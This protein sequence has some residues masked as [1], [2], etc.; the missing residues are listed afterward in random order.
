MNELKIKGQGASDSSSKKGFVWS[1]VVVVFAGVLGL[2]F[3]LMMDRSAP[4]DV[5]PDGAT[6]IKVPA[7]EADHPVM[8]KKKQEE[9][10]S[11]PDDQVKEPKTILKSVKKE[12]KV[13]EK[14][15]LAEIERKKR[16]AKARELAR[17]KED[18][19][20]YEEIVKSKDGKTRKSEAWK[21]LVSKYPDRAEGV[22]EG[23]TITL[24]D[25][26]ARLYVNTVPKNAN[27]HIRDIEPA[28]QQ[29]MKLKHGKYHISVTA[30]DHV[31]KSQWV[32]LKAGKT[33]KITVVLTEFAQLYINTT[34][35][36]AIITILESKVKYKAGVKIA[37]GSYMIEVSKNEYIGQAIDI[38]LSAGKT[39]KVTL[40]LERGYKN[41]LGMKFVYIKPGSF[42]MGS[43]GS[44]SGR[45]NDETQHYVT[46]S[47]RY[48]MQTTEVTQGQWK[49]LM[50]YNPSFF[51]NCGDKC[52]VENLSWNDTQN[53]IQ[54]LNNLEKG[55]N[56]R[57][58]TEAEWEY[59]SR[60]GTTTAF[61]F[62]NCI[63]SEQVNFDGNNPLSGCP[64][65]KYKETPVPVASF[66]ANELELY[67][68]H[69][70]VWEWCSDWY[71]EYTLGSIND[72]T[73]PTSGSHRV[74]RG[75]SWNNFAR[76]CRS[77]YRFKNEPDYRKHSL[78]FRLI[79]IP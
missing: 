25:G 16:E 70:N 54:Q 22:E 14:D 72:P 27:V 35:D 47:T 36:D 42:M 17:L 78:G 3:F 66:P 13:S 24:L 69:G 48:Y 67:D 62:G 51:K 21:A 4:R 9:K 30:K 55:K 26:F 73:G 20:K 5:L 7:L 18:I 11:K 71:G 79:R 46:L 38:S 63:T 34:P 57:L 58:P 33:T 19:R 44:E 76:F 50:G 29:G 28:Y 31:E 64:K 1:V 40:V 41:T 53:F 23:D 52:P 56:Y 10:I 15:R 45:V 8:K 49:Q 32:E 77:A 74:R 68:M 59:A 75:G 2:I 65:G 6:V 61:S 37:P 43:S 12:I 60:A 39:K